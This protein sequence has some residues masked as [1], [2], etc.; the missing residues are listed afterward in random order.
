MI[1]V[2]AVDHFGL[3]GRAEAVARSL[4]ALFVR[5]RDREVPA[6][7]AAHAPRRPAI[8]CADARCLPWIV[9]VAERQRDWR[10]VPAAAEHA[11]EEIGEEVAGLRRKRQATRNR[12]RN[13]SG[14]AHARSHAHRGLLK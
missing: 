6:V 11:A 2:I 12:Q 3:A 7:A 14:C 10:T 5:A 1:D 8:A 4:A 9:V 13:A